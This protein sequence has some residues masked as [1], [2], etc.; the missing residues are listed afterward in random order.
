MN[1]FFYQGIKP[2]YFSQ[3]GLLFLNPPEFTSE[4]FL[5]QARAK[6]ISNNIRPVFRRASRFFNPARVAVKFCTD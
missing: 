6:L 3:V 2:I 1:Y 5:D 4:S